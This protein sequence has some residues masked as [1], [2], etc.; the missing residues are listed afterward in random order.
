MKK[1]QEDCYFWIDESIPRENRTIS[2]FCTSCR[3]RERPDIGWFWQG[4]TLGYGPFD[5][6]CC[7][8]GHMIHSAERDNSENKK[9]EDQVS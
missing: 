1:T 7:V 8:C 3:D 6:V 2:I 9:S 5:F 4:S